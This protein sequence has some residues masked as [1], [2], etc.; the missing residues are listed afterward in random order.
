MADGCF[1]LT[2]EVASNFLHFELYFEGMVGTVELS[3][4]VKIAF[5]KQCMP[6]QGFPQ[7]METSV[8]VMTGT[9][10]TTVTSFQN[11]KLDNWN[12]TSKLEIQ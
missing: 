9:S 8:L 7:G 12:F 11:L 1:E 3:L 4:L 10:V 5:C 2:L 6:L